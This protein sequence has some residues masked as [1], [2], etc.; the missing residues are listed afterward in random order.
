[1][2]TA[3]E[4]QEAGQDIFFDPH[5]P[6]QVTSPD[7][8]LSSLKTAS[9]WQLIVSGNLTWH[10]PHH[11][12]QLTAWSL[13]LRSWRNRAPGSVFL[14]TLTPAFILGD[15]NIELFSVLAFQFLNLL[16]SALAQHPIHIVTLQT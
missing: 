3:D 5:C 4:H 8:S 10:L 16:T 6:F 13:L 14:S 7:S 11:G 9:S 15:F 1:M 12:Y 2:V